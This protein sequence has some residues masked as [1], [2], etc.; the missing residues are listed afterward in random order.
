[1]SEHLLTGKTGENLAVNFLKANGYRIIE[2]N[3]KN[4][5]GEIDIIAQEKDVICFVEVKTRHNDLL[6]SPFEAVTKRKQRQIAKVAQSYINAKR[7]G[8]NNFRFDVVGITLNEREPPKIELLKD[9]F[10]ID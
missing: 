7:L 5:F 8:N 6:G 3:Y 1:M 4:I 10:A 2:K 9:A